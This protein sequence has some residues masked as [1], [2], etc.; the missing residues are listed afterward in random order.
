MK[1]CRSTR[2]HTR[3][4]GRRKARGAVVGREQR[5]ARRRRDTFWKKMHGA[6]IASP[7]LAAPSFPDDNLQRFVDGRCS[8]RR[9]LQLNFNVSQIH[10][11][12]SRPA[13]PAV[14]RA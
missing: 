6:A 4:S 3:T 7:H 1:T 9:L 11:L 13:R 2:T 5:R 8:W 12:R 14:C 10:L